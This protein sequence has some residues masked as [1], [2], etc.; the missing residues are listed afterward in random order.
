MEN[1]VGTFLKISHKKQHGD[2]LEWLIQCWIANSVSFKMRHG[3]AFQQP[4]KW[5]N[6]L[7]KYKEISKFDSEKI[8]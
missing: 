1:H 5:N 4:Q 7:R 6:M 3:P 8:K 2:I